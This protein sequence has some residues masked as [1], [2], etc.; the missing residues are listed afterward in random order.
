[1]SE[2]SGLLRTGPVGCRRRRLAHSKQFVLLLP[3]NTLLNL[4]HCQLTGFFSAPPLLAKYTHIDHFPGFSFHSLPC[5]DVA[6]LPIY[7][8]GVQIEFQPRRRRTIPLIK[9]VVSVN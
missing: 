1:M 4:F 6:I 7:R 3:T 2:E 5:F 8:L 9:L